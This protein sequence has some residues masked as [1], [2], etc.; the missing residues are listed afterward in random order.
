MVVQE[1]KKMKP[2][3]KCNVAGGTVITTASKVAIHLTSMIMFNS[4]KLRE[5]TLSRIID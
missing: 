2:D 4:H 3:S 1:K 5:I